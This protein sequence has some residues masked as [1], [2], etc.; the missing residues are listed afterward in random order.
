M[1]TDDVTIHLLEFFD[2]NDV[3]GDLVNMD[4]LEDGTVSDV[5]RLIE[6]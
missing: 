2:E 5:L 6:R 3:Q 1:I 4:E